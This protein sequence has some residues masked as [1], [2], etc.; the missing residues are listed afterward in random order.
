M[1]QELKALDDNGTWD[2]VTLPKGKRPIA[3]R[4]VYKVKYKESFK[5]RLVAKGFTQREGIDFHETFSLVVNF[6]TAKSLV[7]LVVKH[8]WD[9]HQF[10][11]SNAFLLGD[12]HEEVYMK[13]PPSHAIDSPSLVCR[14][15]K[16]LYGLRQASRQWYAKF[17][18]ALR[19]QGL[20][21]FSK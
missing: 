5:A 11:V 7:A 4:W 3:C 2:I 12:L 18:S 9:I 20:Y 10:D 8:N 6:T 13:L 19:A 15:K 16:S 21:S 17:S 14:I 1:Q